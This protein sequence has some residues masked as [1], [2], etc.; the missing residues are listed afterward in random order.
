MRTPGNTITTIRLPKDVQQWLRERAA[1]YGGSASAEIVRL[2]RQA[3]DADVGIG[4]STT[5]VE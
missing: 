4:K 1:Y 5:A 3:M 2:C